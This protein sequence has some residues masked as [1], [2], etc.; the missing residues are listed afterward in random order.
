VLPIISI[1][2]VLL[3]GHVTGGVRVLIWTCWGLW[4]WLVMTWAEFQHGWRT[5]QQF[6]VEKDWKHGL[7]QK[8]VTLNT[9]WDIVCLTF[10][11]PH[12]TTSS[13]Q[14]HRRQ[15]TIGSLQ[16]SNVWMK[17]T[18]LQSD[19]KVL[20][21]ICYGHAGSAIK[22]LVAIHYSVLDARNGYIRNVVV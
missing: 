19:E 4:Q 10:Q 1:A 14:S 20:Q 15:P 13:F 5:V 16:T 11:L 18:N 12:I 17:A 8:V 2:I 9:C 3:P 6:S 7:M 21:F 22:V